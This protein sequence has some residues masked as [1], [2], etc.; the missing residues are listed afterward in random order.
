MAYVDLPKNRWIFKQEVLWILGGTLV[1]TLFLFVLFYRL[2][3]MYFDRAVQE[4]KS[5]MVQLVTMSRS[6][7]GPIIVEVRQGNLSVEEGRNRVRDLVRRMV[8]I[9]EGGENYI[10]MSSYEGIML[11]QPFEPEKEMSNQYDLKDSKG[12]YIIRELIRSA[13]EHPDGGFVTYHYYLP[14]IKEE[15]EKVAYVIGIPELRSYLGTGMYTYKIAE[16]KKTILHE[17][18]L[19]TSAIIV[20]L[21]IPIFLSLREL[22][23]KNIGLLNEIAERK[24]VQ[25][26]LQESEAMLRSIFDTAPIGSALIANRE[27]I[28]VN[29][30]FCQ[31]VGYSRDE[32]LGQ[33]TLMLYPN[34]E[35]YDRV[36][37]ELYGQTKKEGLGIM[38]T[39]LKRKD[40]KII[41]IHLSSNPVDPDDWSKGLTTTILDITDF[42]QAQAALKLDELR[43]ETLLKL[44][45]MR[46]TD[47]TETIMKFTLEEAVHLTQSLVGCLAFVN[48]DQS[49]MTMHNVWCKTK[50]I[51]CNIPDEIFECA[52]EKTG[53]WGEAV[54]QRKPIITN[55]Y[56]IDNPYKKGYPE[57]HIAIKRHMNVPIL[58]GEKIVIV[59]GVA[60]KETDYDQTD[61][62]QLTLLMSGMWRILKQKR[63]DEQIRELNRSLEQRVRERTAELNEAN[64]EL[65]AFAY[66]ISHD[67]R[68]PLRSIAGFSQILMEENTQLSEDSK[69]LLERVRAA[70]HRMEQMIEALLH[71]SR[72]IRAELHRSSVDLSKMAH[73]IADQLR[74]SNPNRQVE[75]IIQ[76]NL[77][78]NA[79]PDLI[80]VVIENL[81]NNAWKYTRNRPNAKV[82]VGAE[83]EQGETVYFVRDNGAGF[84]EA[85]AGKLF[86][87]FQRLHRT[88][89]FEGTGIGLATVARIIRRHGGRIWAHGEVDKGAT[90]YFTLPG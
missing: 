58:D 60:N 5:S 69:Q 78:V 51:E 42:K 38:E 43:L 22:Y 52:L 49:L 71:F 54:R 48:E 37:R 24:K 46:E 73:D 70:A 14:K 68:A 31:V 82:E 90:F 33:D 81:L 83:Q 20:L 75:F 15:K 45:Q 64:K 40:G 66:S 9:D 12:K 74:E 56:A 41:N 8:Y 89:E 19:W 86:Q 26:A 25:R 32:L 57:G 67:L 7:I 28:K 55:N 65:E 47:D 35:E 29:R 23:N 27:F 18:L 17:S 88:E 13:R 36:G 84:N 61:V 11:V 62:R 76:P 1:V 50:A 16:E 80:C 10:F 4:R 30:W 87:A 77:L 2:S 21:M 79:D 59:A 3:D 6:V 85:Y 72:M 63:M 53:L 39:R 44:N 34:Q